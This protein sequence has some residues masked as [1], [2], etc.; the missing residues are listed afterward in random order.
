MTTNLL[1]LRFPYLCPCLLLIGSMTL[2]GS[3][4]VTPPSS[5]QVPPAPT[6][7]VSTHMVLLDVV[8]TDKRGKAITGLRPDDFVVEENGTVQ[9]IAS[10]SCWRELASGGFA[11]WDLLEPGAVSFA[12]WPHHGDGPRRD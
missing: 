9:K 6:I 10:L 8:V 7:R 2:G 1:R 4:Q 11:T 5:S 3:S 12:R